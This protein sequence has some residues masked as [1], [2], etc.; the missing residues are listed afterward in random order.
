MM[1]DRP[2]PPRPLPRNPGRAIAHLREADP[3]LARAIDRVGRF[4][5]RDRPPGLRGICHAI[6]G[7]QLSMIA[8]G[9]IC[10]RFDALF[11][12]RGDVEAATLARTP[13]GDLRAVGL[14]RAKISA[15]RA[16]ADLW[17][18]GKLTGE[19]IRSMGDDALIDIL[20][21][22][23]GIGP[24][25]VHMVLIFN[26]RRPDVL[27]VEDLGLRVAIEKLH[28]LDHRPNADT[29]RTIAEPWRP[30]R[31]VATWYCWESL[32]QED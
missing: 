9:R 16:L 6:I 28:N 4:S 30:W 17:L 19:T 22:V 26:L 25:T 11:D 7:Q 5:L 15:V 21:R 27:P 18:R 32:K 1:P 31:T 10:E 13:D 2:A 20:T 14:S 23:K 12:G 24:W 8:A 3:A 29:V